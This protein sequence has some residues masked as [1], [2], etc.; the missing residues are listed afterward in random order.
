[1][2]HHGGLVDGPTLQFLETELANA[3]EKHIVV[4]GHH[5]LAETWA[6][7]QFETWD[8]EY[9]VQNRDMVCALL[10]SNP[11]VRAYL[12]GHHHASHIGFIPAEQAENGVSHILRP[13]L[14]AFP[15]GA[16]ILS[17]TEDSLVVETIEPRIEGLMEEGL[18][19]VLG[20]RKIQRFKTL[21][22]PRSF[23]EY[24]GG[25]ESDRNVR[26]PHNPLSQARPDIPNSSMVLV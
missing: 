17:F 22:H 12:C 3:S 2:G 13:S 6:P 19:A 20:G 23:T 9:L 8:R 14:S 16:R 15:H 24:L 1:M 26:L 10:A 25:R 11:N 18:T 21:N 4:F 7:A 5:L